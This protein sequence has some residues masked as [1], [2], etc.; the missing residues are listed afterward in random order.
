MGCG[1]A[2][3]RPPVRLAAAEDL[4]GVMQRLAEQYRSE[5]EQEV[6]I[7]PLPL[8]RSGDD[9]GRRPSGPG[10]DLAVTASSVQLAALIKAHR[11][12][13]TGSQR[14][15]LVQLA[16]WTPPD[17][18]LAPPVSLTDIISP[19]FRAV[20]LPAAADSVTGAAARQALER[21]G[22]WTQ[23]EPRLVQAARDAH[24]VELARHRVVD[25]G[26]VALHTARAAG[27][28]HVAVD[29]DAHAPIELRLSPCQGGS[30]KRSRAFVEFTTSARGQAILQ[31][32]G[33][34][35]PVLATRSS[36]PER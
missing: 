20:G 21:A 31:R 27:G 23:T 24:V 2:E 13:A 36:P 15:G 33:V 28:R 10:C 4:A 3:P 12:A 8:P 9:P 14:L 6:Q 19:R 35:Q 7:T 34:A 5:S 16:V 26:I 30:Q 32:L 11:I 17:S 22:L 29:L 18:R 25:V 1:R